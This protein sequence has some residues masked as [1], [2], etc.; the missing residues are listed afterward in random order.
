MISLELYLSALISWDEY[1]RLA[2]QPELHPDYDT[3]IGALLGEQA[4]P[5]KPRDFVRIWEERLAYE[6]KYNAPNAKRLR[7]TERITL[8]M[9]RLAGITSL[10]A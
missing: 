10:R 3:T 6:R 5:D 7:A 2:F 8:M 4:D 9:R 1:A